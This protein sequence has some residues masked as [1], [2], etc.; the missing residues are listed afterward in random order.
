MVNNM[1]KQ[2]LYIIVPCFNE[3]EVLKDTYSIINEKMSSLIDNNLIT[4]DSKVLFVND[5]SKDKTW[6]IITT[7]CSKNSRFLGINLSRNF[8]HQNALLAGFSEAI[9]K[10]DMTITMDAD[11]QDDINVIDEMIE[12][13]YEGNDIIYG[14]RN[15]RKN[16]TFFKR[17]SAQCFYKLMKF[18]GVNIYY[19]HADY[20]LVSNH[21]LKELLE[22]K[23]VNVFL[24]G[25]FPYLGFKQDFV[26]YER[27]KRMKGE[28]KYP[29]KKMISFATDGISSFSIK[30][31]RMI[32]VLGVVILI[33]SFCIML[34]SIIQKLIG[35]TV[36]GWTFLMISIWFIGGVQ[37]M[38]LG[39]IGEYIGKTY[40]E[41]KERPKFIIKDRI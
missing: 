18:L 39:I 13:Y 26:F 8:G 33:V 6:D 23:E 16:D 36:A 21:V 9:D 41:T 5:G 32:F 19:N 7:L 27:K 14:I 3:E 17:N 25:L 15:D 37:M 11:L 10:C 35:N 30:P 29:L 40:M 31:L 34:Y 20:R 24:R 1:K 22:F 2:K 28:S 12:K 38:S 4:K